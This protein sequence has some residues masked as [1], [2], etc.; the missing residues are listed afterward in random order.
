M[1]EQDVTLRRDN[2]RLEMGCLLSLLAMRNR[3]T[4]QS[5]WRSGFR[6][7]PVDLGRPYEVLRSSRKDRR[8]DLRDA[9]LERLGR[10]VLHIGWE[11]DVV[12]HDQE[13]QIA[14]RG[15]ASRAV[16]R[17]SLLPAWGSR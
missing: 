17:T 3:P 11:D 10:P 4:V 12:V 5:S 14:G 16:T 13:V 8:E 15:N 7:P 9:V 2:G 1:T 6:R